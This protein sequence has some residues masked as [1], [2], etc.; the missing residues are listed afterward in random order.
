MELEKQLWAAQNETTQLRDMLEGADKERLQ[1]RQ[2]NEDHDQ[3][4]VVL[5]EENVEIRRQL[6][7]EVYS[8]TRRTGILHH[9]NAV[10]QS[11]R[12]LVPSNFCLVDETR[13]LYQFGTKQISLQVIKGVSGEDELMVAVGRGYLS[14]QDYVLKY[15]MMEKQKM[16]S[17][18]LCDGMSADIPMMTVGSVP[19]KPTSASPRKGRPMSAVVRH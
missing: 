4:C 5:E 18:N 6:E 14:F 15:G 11:L 9:I 13:E 17:D 16:A 1:F 3:K 8:R 7:V 12:R 2:E 10:L 19:Q